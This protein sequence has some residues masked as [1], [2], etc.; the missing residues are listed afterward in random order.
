[1]LVSVVERAVASNKPALP[2]CAEHLKSYPVSFVVK[3]ILILADIKQETS[4][5]TIDPVSTEKLEALSPV[6]R[7]FHDSAISGRQQLTFSGGRSHKRYAEVP[8]AD[9]AASVGAGGSP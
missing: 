8:L 1:M 4:F 9:S 5:C 3:C 7:T 2:Y 6:L